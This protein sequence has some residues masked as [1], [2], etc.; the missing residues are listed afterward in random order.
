M[1]KST[2]IALCLFAALPLLAQQ[3]KEYKAYVVSNAHLD[4][5]W[6]WD[7][8]TTINDYIPKT[9]RQTSG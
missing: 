5:Q 4:T 6:N 8:Q 1:K 3:K 9:L 7:I 2:L